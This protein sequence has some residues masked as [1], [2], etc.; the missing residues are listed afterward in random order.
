MRGRARPRQPPPMVTPARPGNG[1]RRTRA[2]AFLAGAAAPVAEVRA[3][4]G[5]GSGWLGGAKGGFAADVH[6]MESTG[7]IGRGSGAIRA[8]A[9]PTR[10][11][12][13]AGR[14]RNLTQP[15]G[16]RCSR[17]LL[18]RTTRQEW[19][20]RFPPANERRLH[21]IKFT[22]MTGDRQPLMAIG[23]RQP[24]QSPAAAAN[25]G[26]RPRTRLA[27]ARGRT[28]WSSPSHELRRARQGDARAPLPSGC[29]THG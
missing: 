26:R 18:L 19:F 4:V 11:A 2:E 6:R 22:A 27:L 24:R 10:L 29:V 23:H 14:V 1:G 25:R 3:W 5:I 13:P 12:G 17:K 9:T 7:V 16:H 28:R 20:S 21:R 15:T 8:I